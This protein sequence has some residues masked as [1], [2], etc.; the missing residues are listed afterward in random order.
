[1]ADRQFTLDLARLFIAA[2]WELGHL[3]EAEVEALSDLV[4]SLPGIAGPD[5]VAL[6]G[7]GLHRASS[8]ERENLLA[9]VL[10]AVRT[11]E[12]VALM[13]DTIQALVE[14][15]R[16]IRSEDE[17]AL[18]EI[19]EAV[20]ENDTG[21]IDPLARMVRQAV[22]RRHQTFR[23]GPN[24]DERIDAY[25]HD[26][27]YFDLAADME[28]QGLP[29]DLP[30]PQAR[31]LCLPAGLMARLPWLDR[32]MG[33]HDKS[34]MAR[35]LQDEWAVSEPAARVMA[36]ICT[37]RA[38]KGLD[39]CRL[40][41]TYFEA[42]M[43]EERRGLI[44]CLLRV[45]HAVGRTSADETEDIRQIAVLLKLPPSDFVDAGPAFPGR[46]GPGLRR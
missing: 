19:E 40:A 13:R 2:A 31:K 22:M 30:E 34:A 26:T 7:Q 11:P 44:R 36:T 5:W 38:A 21:F 43:P 20:G 45:A 35:V 15:D 4:Y 28:V 17:E 23:G 39:E 24:G 41:R 9:A 37:D 1:M 42:T 46:G 12:D 14:T 18:L 25:I 29:M 32:E 16:Q 8:E 10:E 3:H 6:Q 27:L 33:D